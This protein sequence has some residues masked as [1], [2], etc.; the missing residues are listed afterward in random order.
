[1]KYWNALETKAANV[2][3]LMIIE[4]MELDTRAGGVFGVWRKCV[5]ENAM[6]NR[7][8]SVVGV[9]GKTVAMLEAEWAQVVHSEN[10]IGM[11]MGVKDR[12]DVPD[13]FAQ[14]L[15]AEVLPRVDDHGM[16]VPLHGD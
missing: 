1:M 2:H 8:G 11:R 15:L 9:E 7:S 6:Q 14:N 16:R 10:V 13:V 4:G 12:V 3:R 5:F